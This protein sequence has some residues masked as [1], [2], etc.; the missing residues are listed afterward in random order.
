[1]HERYALSETALHRL[2]DFLD[3]ESNDHGLDFCGTHGFLCGVTVGPARDPAEWLDTLFEGVIPADLT[4][5][6]MAWQK[7]LHACLYHEDTP[8]LPCPLTVDLNGNELTDWCIG[9]MEAVFSHEKA[10][11]TRDEQLVVEMTLP[12]VAVSGLVDDPELDQIRRNQRLL[13]QLAKQ[14]PVILTEIYL[15]F[16][17]PQNV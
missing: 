2:Q 17:A 11:Y 8:P 1:M 4:T 10:W 3:G 13:Q 14:I 6:L 12:M 9:F 15:H 16:N 7:S 5:D